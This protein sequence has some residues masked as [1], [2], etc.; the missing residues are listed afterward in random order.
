MNGL[1]YAQSGDYSKTI[2]YWQK[3]ENLSFSKLVNQELFVLSD[4]QRIEKMKSLRNI[5]DIFMS[6]DEREKG[7]VEALNSL[8]LNQQLSTKNILLSAAENI[9]KSILAGNNVEI[10]ELYAKWS[11]LKE[12]LSWCYTQSKEDLTTLE[13]NIPALE[14]V[15][16]SLESMIAHRSATF[17]AARMQSSITWPDVR[18]RLAPDEAALEIVRYHQHILTQ[19]DSVRYAVF[20]ITPESI[21]TPSVVFF[22][23]G[24]RLEQ[25][26]IEKYLA[27]C[28]APEG[29][30]DTRELYELFWRPIEPFL[31][32]AHRVYISADGA[33]QKINLAALR[34]PG[35]QSLIE[36][37]DIRPVFS[38]KDV[39]KTNNTSIPEYGDR[40]A[41]LVGN[42]AYGGKNISGSDAGKK[43]RSAIDTSNIWKVLVPDQMSSL[44]RELSGTRGLQL[45]PLP[46]TQKE[47]EDI[48]NLLQR[49]GWQTTLICQGEATETAVKAVKSPAI[50][51]LATHGYFLANARSGATGFSGKQAERNP[52][53]RSMLFFAGAQ[54]TLD[55][56]GAQDPASWAKQNPDD[57]GILTAFEAQIMNLY[58]TELVVLSACKSAQGK[59]QNGEGVYGLQRALRIAGA[60]SVLLSLWDVDD[61]VGRE[62]M[63]LFYEKWLGGMTRASAFRATQLAIREK[64]P[65]PFYWAGF[66]LME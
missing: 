40:S 23:D 9:R 41:I 60:K 65:L 4:Q 1:Y 32:N 35:G 15:V 8:A 3:V 52:M 53:L 25:I 56:K 27:A 58:G 11:N 48:S 49:N 39:E 14:S 45:N 26:V 34:S 24:A 10:K 13:I 22:T 44:V 6:Y 31:K 61:K 63:V 29:K 43:T 17:A 66:I 55:R 59:I 62:F 30:G 64:H 20:I 7:H 28:T 46:E 21:E 57:D 42:P 2:P 19:T 36:K 33:F 38:L 47:V 50:L 37:M 51:H 12:H 16:D 18:S 54:S 5:S